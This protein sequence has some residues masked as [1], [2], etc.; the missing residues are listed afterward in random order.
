MLLDAER[1]VVLWVQ[2]YKAI[3]EENRQLPPLKPV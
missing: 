2:H 3:T 1:L